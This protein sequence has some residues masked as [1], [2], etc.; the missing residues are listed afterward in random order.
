MTVAVTPV[1]ACTKILDP[2]ANRNDGRVDDPLTLINQ[3]L[4][5]KAIGK[6]KRVWIGERSI[7]IVNKNGKVRRGKEH[8]ETGEGR[9][10]QGR[11][12]HQR[13]IQ[14]L[15]GEVTKLRRYI[16]E[17]EQGQGKSIPRKWKD[18][19]DLRGDEQRNREERDGMRRK[20]QTEAELDWHQEG[21]ST[22]RRGNRWRTEEVQSDGTMVTKGKNGK[23][24]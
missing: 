2:S 3:P 12:E 14:T 10:H 21:S 4:K 20:S 6:R 16:Q 22:E 23:N 13:Q 9:E 7:H 15:Q 8:D 24:R 18:G 17:I 1:K 11:E 19:E 5:G